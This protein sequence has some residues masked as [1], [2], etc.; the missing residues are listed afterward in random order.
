MPQSKPYIWQKVG[1][2]SE[3]PHEILEA[4][5][6]AGIDAGEKGRAGSYMHIDHSLVIE[7]VNERFKGQLEVLDTNEALEKY[8]WLK[9]YLW[10]LVDPEKDEYTRKA[11]QASGGY[12]MRI[13]SGANVTFPIQSCLMI[14]GDNV[15]Q[16]VHNI[17]IAEEGSQ[18][19]IITGCLTHPDVKSG[20]HI[21]ISEFYVKKKATLNFTMIHNWAEDTFVRPRS[22]ALI[23]DAAAFVSNYVALKPVKDLQMYPAAFCSGRNSRAVF[24]SILYGT[25]KSLIDVGSK[26]VLSGESSSGEIVS[27][28]IAKDSAKIIARGMLS[29]ENSPVKAHM[30]CKG[31]LLN[32]GAV[33]H[34][35]PELV[36]SRKDVE[37]SHEAA[38]G[39][40]ADKEINYLMSR[41]LTKEDATSVIVR[42]FLDVNIMG[43]PEKLGRDIR[44]MVEK[45]T[46]GL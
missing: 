16:K 14:A 27:R 11:K 26:I 32:D 41:G 2:L 37:L 28:A 46:G 45:T 38:V 42:G 7:K 35:I 44:E 1:E 20:Q 39:K 30:E 31:L 5:A 12:F 22:A 19:R 15:E 34:S 13:L 36:G 10:K 40:I 18:A 23:E 17:I 29:G 9:D 21:G 3:L 4:A 8:D 43:L 25:G 6:N 33:I 24:N